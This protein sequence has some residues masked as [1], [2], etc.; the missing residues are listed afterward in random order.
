MPRR[1]QI[2]EKIVQRYD[3]VKRMCIKPSNLCTS[4]PLASGENDIDIHRN[5][6]VVNKSEFHDERNMMEVV[7]ER[8]E[9]TL[10][11][12]AMG[13]GGVSRLGATN[14]FEQNQLKEKIFASKR[15]IEKE[16]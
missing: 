14:K 16:R 11:A 1:G 15:R 2:R 6:S 5:V 3:G 12:A 13:A 8:G 9:G 7:N 4:D 10:I